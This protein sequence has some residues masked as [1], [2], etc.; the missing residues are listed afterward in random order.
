MGYGEETDLCLRARRAGF[1]LTLADDAFVYHHKS[2]SFGAAGRS[3]LT[4]AGGLEMTNKHLGVNIAALERT[5]QS[6]PAL[7]RVRARMLDRLKEI[8]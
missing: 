6:C 1:R 5:M 4:R 7:V 3:P 8:T 2:L